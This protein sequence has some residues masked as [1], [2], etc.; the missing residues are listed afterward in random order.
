MACDALKGVS[1][2]L[3]FKKDP[4]PLTASDVNALKW[5]KHPLIEGYADFYGRHKDERLCL[6]GL[7]PLADKGQ[8]PYFEK[9]YGETLRYNFPFESACVWEDIRNK[10]RAAE[11]GDKVQYGTVTIGSEGCGIY[12][13]YIICGQHAGEVWL[14]T[15]QGTTPVADHMTLETWHGKMLEQGAL[16]WHP[17]LSTWGREK[18]D[19]FYGHAVLKG[20]AAKQNTLGVSSPLVPFL[21]NPPLRI[22]GA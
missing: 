10:K 16:F 6:Y 11:A 12:W 17:A 18:D 15:E 3:G 4:Y 20:V 19:F 2:L 14:Q 1:L 13:I 9:P 21:H 22:R 5:E 7:L 8:S